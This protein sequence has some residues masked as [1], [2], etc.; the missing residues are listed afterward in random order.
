M[1]LQESNEKIHSRNDEGSDIPNSGKRVAVSGVPT[2]P[3][4]AEQRE[5]LEQLLM[6]IKRQLK[7]VLPSYMIPA[8]FVP[9]TNIP[10]STANKTDR[11]AL[12][13]LASSMT[14]QQLNAFSSVSAL[15]RS[16]ETVAEFRMQK[17]WA[18]TLG[19][20][21]ESVGADDSFLEIG[22]DSLGAMRLVE[23]A[24]AVGLNIKVEDIFR[25]PILS[26]MI[27]ATTEQHDND[28]LLAEVPA[29]SLL[30]DQDPE[31]LAIIRQQASTQCHCAEEKIEDAYPCT[32]LQAG[33]MA[34]SIRDVGSYIARFVFLLPETVDVQRYQSA[35][36]HIGTQ[37]SAL[38]TRICRIS[39]SSSSNFS[40]FTQVV[41]N[42]HL[43]WEQS[44]DLDLESYIRKDEMSP[45]D[46]GRP[47]FRFAV[48]V[49][50]VKDNQRYFV[51][52]A[53][54]AI[55][56]GWSIEPLFKQVERVYLGQQP[57]RT[58]AHF[59]RFI[60]HLLDQDHNSSKAY[61]RAQL[62]GAAPPS[63]PRLPPNYRPTPRT[64][65]SHTFS[66]TTTNTA[67]PKNAAAG[68]TM[69][70][71][72]RAAW[73]II[74]A[75]YS[76][77]EDIVFATT[78]S[79]R[80]AP[81]AGIQEVLSPTFTTVPV[82]VNVDKR[83]KLVEFMAA[84]Q[85]QATEMMP[86]EQ[87]GMQNI[88]QLSTEISEACESQALLVIQQRLPGLTDERD[89]RSLGL[90]RLARDSS[91]AFHSFAI[92]M[93][94][95]IAAGHAVDLVATFDSTIIDE[96]QSMRIL[97][98]MDHVLQQLCSETICGGSVVDEVNILSPAD[99][100]EIIR[101]NSTEL[102]TS[103]VCVHHLVE[104]QARLQ[105]QDPAICSWD[106]EM[107][108]SELDKQSSRLARV[109]LESGNIQT[110]KL[111]PLLFEKSLWTIVAM[112]G[113]LKAGGACVV[114][115]PAHPTARLR[116]IVQDVEAK[117][118]LSSRSC[119]S[120][121]RGLVDMVIAVD[122]TFFDALPGSMQH[123]HDVDGPLHERV[124]V[125]PQDSAFIL[126]T[127]GSTGKPKGIVIDHSAF[128]SSINGHASI[129]R[130]G[131]RCFQFTAY[132]SDV[133]I[134]EIFTTLSLGSCVCVP[135]DYER[136]NGLASSIRRM[137]VNW[138]FLTPSVA[139]L[140][141]PAEVPSL[142]TLVFGGETATPKN[143]STWAPVVFLINSF[144]PAVCT[145]RRVYH[146]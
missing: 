87:Y 43:I 143:I 116:G 54:H 48:V 16:P 20:K 96:R 71:K 103:Q 68:I 52:T 82:R 42:E 70:T 64:Q 111:I 77:S 113:I 75:R 66:P 25:Y 146:F 12:R 73:A 104:R 9:I 102:Q 45:M 17:L 29:F 100:E 37:N 92:S 128:S 5:L 23:E 15:A 124:E 35:W 145:F 97:H 144:G 109:L 86:F 105:P 95:T 108:Y 31:D 127:S 74:C 24:R 60:K 18:K 140:V 99:R 130:F 106:G 65:I 61:W 121:A 129:L 132:T 120:T 69:A 55:Y 133:S 53:H 44:G 10:Y 51:L 84:I 90:V 134:G 79:G 142:Q 19:I 131:S 11:K 28:E 112:L 33:I 27:S 41:V 2:A 126:F 39:S 91:V 3:M 94:C 141:D 98:Q 101:W 118:V 47:L 62:T 115:D 83:Q 67:D 114:L 88:K 137:N 50:S 36:N 56:D 40:E 22:G 78:L 80:T 4:T 76:D 119:F 30:G 93:E 38:Q 1:T 89:E 136:M 138:A 57:I 26:D 135:S 125:T 59:N 117:V 139:A 63:F 13:D 34:L 7:H 8:F 123:H 32:P 122:K 58:A 81:V 14:V 72:I 6:K 49:P 107:T 85:D 21:V 46:L 110:H